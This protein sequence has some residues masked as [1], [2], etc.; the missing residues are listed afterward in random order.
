MSAGCIVVACVVCCGV[1]AVAIFLL[2]RRGDDKGRSVCNA[3]AKLGLLLDSQ[4]GGG[5]LSENA[6]VFSGFIK[7][8]EKRILAFLIEKEA[9]RRSLERDVILS[10][11][12]KYGTELVRPAY[13]AQDQLGK[14]GINPMDVTRLQ[15]EWI[16]QNGGNPNA[17]PPSR[18]VE[19]ILIERN[20]G[21]AASICAA[22]NS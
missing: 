12:G 4:S 10:L 14:Y 20:K 6:H 3:D 13:D 7:Q 8:H 15:K 11:R 21:N 16:K 5:V 1:A 22:V 17:H 9:E 19:R 18:E 2:K